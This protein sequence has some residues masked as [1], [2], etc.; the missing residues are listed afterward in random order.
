MLF[1]GKILKL[2]YLNLHS[3]AN[4]Q[5]L[6]VKIE[7]HISITLQ[8]KTQQK[9]MKSIKAGIRTRHSHYRR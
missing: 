6:T 7:H 8:L 1:Q 5:R 2:A 3:L 4:N 9:D